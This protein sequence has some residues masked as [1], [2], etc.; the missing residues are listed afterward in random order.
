MLTPLVSENLAQMAFERLE[1]AILSGAIEPGNRM[2]EADLARQ[3]GISRGPLREAIG[4]LEG[5]GLVTRVANQGPRVTSL[6]KSEL[7]DLLVFREAVEGMAAR[8]AA[9]NAT[10]AEIGQ[11]AALLHAHENDPDIRAGKGY[12]QG[13]GDTDFHLRIAEAS[14]NSRLSNFVSG[15]IY[16]ILRL[17]R[18]RMSAMPG[19][20]HAALEEHRAILTAIQ[21]RDPD[22]AERQMRLHIS[23]S[24]QNVVD[25]M[26]DDDEPVA[27]P[28]RKVGS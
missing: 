28:T 15:P 16:S 18:H 1:R 14:H 27:K 25:H 9:L 12:F 2:S 11:I 24:R 4:R 20:P 6:R 19:R 8:H 23:R 3:L 10:D 7:I 26:L 13:S 17:Y 22:E 5:L 21:K